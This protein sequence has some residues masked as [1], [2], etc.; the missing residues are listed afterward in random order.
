MS[1]SAACARAPRASTSPA[2]AVAGGGDTA[3][4]AGSMVRGGASVSFEPHPLATSI[5]ASIDHTLPRIVR[6]RCCGNRWPPGRSDVRR[7]MDPILGARH[8]TPDTARTRAPITPP[9]P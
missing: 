8:L 3:A 4:R 2:G 1:K 5:S 6:F 7:S 9:A